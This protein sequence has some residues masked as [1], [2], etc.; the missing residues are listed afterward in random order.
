M[1]TII[2]IAFCLWVAKEL[3]LMGAMRKWI[4]GEK[5]EK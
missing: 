5:T 4:H 1:G 2:L 3:D